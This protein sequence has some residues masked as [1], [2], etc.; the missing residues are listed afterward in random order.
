MTYA[1]IAVS[2]FMLVLAWLLIRSFLSPVRKLQA[3]LRQIAEG[4]LRQQI[5]SRTMMSW[6]N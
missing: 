4:D 6:D 5:N 2:L 3:A 1:A